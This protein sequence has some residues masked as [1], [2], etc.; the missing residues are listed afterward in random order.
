[1]LIGLCV[2]WS[3]TGCYRTHTR[4][5]DAG[6]PRDAPS[7]DGG[8]IEVGSIDA[9]QDAAARD[10]LM[11]PDAPQDSGRRVCECCP[12]VTILST[13]GFACA[14]TC[15]GILCT[16]VERRPSEVCFRAPVG[17]EPIELDVSMEGTD[18]CFCGQSLSCE[19][20]GSS[21]RLE[22]CDSVPDC[23]ECG[24]VPAT[25]C[26]LPART[27]GTHRIVQNG[28]WPQV[29]LELDVVE[30]GVPRPE[31][32][33]RT[34]PWDCH[35]R[36]SHEPIPTEL[37]C[38]DST[39][40]PGSRV[41]IHVEGRCERTGGPGQCSVSVLG[42]EITVRATQAGTTCVGEWCTPLIFDCVT[43]PLAAGSYTV[44]VEGLDGVST[45][46]VSDRGE[47]PVEVCRRAE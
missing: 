37:A 34:A 36:W 17:G 29:L 9:G 27:V 4:G 24:A 28:A 3:V 20:E 26:V 40:Q 33:V 14:A 31:V 21:M 38:H 22:F 45:L 8:T 41:T 30:P 42:S 11:A 1:M 15:A 43:P 39:A 2:S 19:A 13:P 35:D 25:R 23:T 44:R 46:E 18:E 16:C 7:M 10:T 47:P 5:D 6:P 12:G 32:C